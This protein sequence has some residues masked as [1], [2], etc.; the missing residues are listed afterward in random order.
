MKLKQFVQTR[1]TIVSL[2]SL[3]VVFA[4]AV[5]AFQ[6]K[7]TDA[8]PSTKPSVGAAVPSQFAFAGAIGWWQGATNKTSVAVFHNTQDCFVSVQHNT[9]T[10][11]AEQAKVQSASNTLINQGYS[12]TPINKLTLAFRTNEGVKQYQ[13][14][15]SSVASQPGASKV[16]GGQEFAYLPLANGHIYIEGYCDTPAELS[17]TIP[18][19]QAFNFDENK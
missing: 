6:H 14:D 1:Y 10:I 8:A 17:A 4:I 19:L 2:A 18:V 9:G 16:E 5:F 12:V 13:L 7:N 3:V 15:Q 11:E